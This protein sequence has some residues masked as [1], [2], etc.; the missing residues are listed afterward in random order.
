MS[1]GL[2]TGRMEATGI[3]S[4]TGMTT[5][6]ALGPVPGIPAAPFSIQGVGEEL[7]LLSRGVFPSS[8]YCV[9]AL[10]SINSLGSP[11]S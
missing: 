1:W 8:G 5:M 7:S 3:L 10:T 4:K 6:P 11:A 2:L 9:V